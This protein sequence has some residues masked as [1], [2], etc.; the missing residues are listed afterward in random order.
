MKDDRGSPQQILQAKGI[1]GV[2]LKLGDKGS[3]FAVPNPATKPASS[4]SRSRRSIRRQPATPST[5]PS[6]PRSCLA[7]PVSK[8]PSSPAPP[9]PSPSPAQERK[10]PWPPSK[11]SN[12]CSTATGS[13]KKSKRRIYKPIPPQTLSS[14]KAK[15]QLLF[16]S[17]RLTLLFCFCTRF[18]FSCLSFPKEICFYSCSNL[19][20]GREQEHSCP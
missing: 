15:N 18:C 11:K 14:C 6:P 7:N 12:K 17:L 5:E 4:P 20:F 10:P 13:K 3:Y 19:A 8:Q 9:L 1:G 2:I 16:L